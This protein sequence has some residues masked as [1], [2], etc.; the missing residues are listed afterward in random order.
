MKDP[1]FVYFLILLVRRL[2][3]NLYKLKKFGI[4]LCRYNKL[5]ITK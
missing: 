1:A 3:Y 4:K 5:S 2:N